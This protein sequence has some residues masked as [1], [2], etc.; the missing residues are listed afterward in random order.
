MCLLIGSTHILV[1]VQAVDLETDLARAI[2]NKVYQAP[3]QSELNQAADLFQ[4][5]MQGGWAD[6]Q[7]LMRRWA[8]LGFKF[9]NVATTNESFW[10]LSE[11]AG[12]EGGRGW[13]LFR[14]NS[15]SSIIM[16]APHAR[17][18]IHT[19]I[20][21]LRLFQ[22][23]QARV[24]AASTITRHRADMAHVDDTF[25]QAFTLAFAQAC[26]S[27][28][29]VQ[30][31]GFDARNHSNA[32]ADIIASA[33]TDSPGGWLADFVQDLKNATSLPVQAYPRDTRL[34]GAT[35]NVQGRALEQAGSCRFLHLEM[36]RELRERLIR[37]DE[38]HRAIL[39]CLTS[40]ESK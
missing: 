17:N 37:D 21:A 34:L 35:L 4:R 27:G 5:T 20:I 39:R 30:L 14:T 23:G 40:A 1:Q 12:K 25:F 2:T 13:Y 29:V 9:Q 15:A 6:H 38:L 16:E 33:G 8:A 7:E 10:L 24:L 19:G 22:T 32:S 31:H 3:T 36:S 26:P 28:L 18:D 11:P